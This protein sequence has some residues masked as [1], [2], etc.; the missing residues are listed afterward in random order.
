M[1]ILFILLFL[2]SMAFAADGW[3]VKEEN[4]F[5][6][7]ENGEKTF[8]IVSDGGEPEFLEKKKF[9][10]TFS[11]LL[12]KSGEVGS[13]KIIVMERALLFKNGKYVEDVPYRNYEKGSDKSFDIKWQ[14]S[15]DSLEI[16]D[17][18]DNRKWK[19]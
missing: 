7:L 18:A 17:E 4:N 12:Y 3:V 13:Q 8:P 6:T 19:F 5:Y 16:I 15:D 2:S 1:K 9:N 11:A 14:F 10:K